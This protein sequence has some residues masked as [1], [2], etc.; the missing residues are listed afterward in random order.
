MSG[1]M[2]FLGLFYFTV[3]TLAPQDLQRKADWRHARSSRVGARDASQFVGPGPETVS[4][5]GVA[6]A[7]LSN[8]RASLDELRDMAD[9]GE[10]WPLGDGT[11]RIHGYFVITAIDERQKHFFPDGTPRQID[12]A[13]DLERVDDDRES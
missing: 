9:S 13:I 2:M 11:G 3:P 6:Y 4:L 10:V 12:F 7:E 1:H 8:G 5:A